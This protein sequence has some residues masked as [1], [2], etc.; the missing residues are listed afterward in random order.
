[1][2]EAD[3]DERGSVNTTG[4]EGGGRQNAS[5]RGGVGPPEQP[6]QLLRL[7]APQRARPDYL[8]HRWEPDPIAAPSRWSAEGSTGSIRE[9]RGAARTEEVGHA[10]PPYRT[11]PN[12]LRLF[13]VNQRRT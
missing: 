12:P 2:Q 1:M 11:E 4:E 9:S 8:A 10:R 7:H 13:I 3:D 5:E 6:A